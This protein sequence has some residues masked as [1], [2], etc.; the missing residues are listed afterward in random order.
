MEAINQQNQAL[1]NQYMHMNIQLLSQKIVSLEKHPEQD[2]RVLSAKEEISEEA[3][4]LRKK[5]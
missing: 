1:F 5:K 4:A 3:K 2:K